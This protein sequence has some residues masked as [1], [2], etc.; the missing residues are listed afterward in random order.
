MYYRNE[1]DQN[2]VSFGCTM[3]YSEK[4]LRLHKGLSFW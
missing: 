3:T 4:D 1:N 2:K